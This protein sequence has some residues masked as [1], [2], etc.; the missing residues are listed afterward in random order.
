MLGYKGECFISRDDIDKGNMVFS[1]GMD[2]QNSYSSHL[3]LCEL[4]TFLENLDAEL[5][6]IDFSNVKF[7]AS[8]LFAVLGCIFMEFVERKPGTNR[9]KITGLNYSIKNLI[10]KNGFSIH[11]SEFE[12][13][14]DKF[15]TV[16]AY[17]QFGRDN[18]KEYEMYLTYSIFSRKDLPEMSKEVSDDIRDSLLELFK[19]VSDHTRSKHIYTCGQFFPKSKMLFFTI[20]DAGETIYKNVLE[21]HRRHKLNQPQYCL[22]WAI[23]EGNTTLDTT[24]PRGIGLSLMKDFVKHNKGS[25]YIISGIETYEMVYSKERYRIFEKYS[26]PGT[27]VSIGFNLKDKTSYKVKEDITIQ[28]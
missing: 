27:I 16:I 11:F 4:A 8:N 22:E 2:L 1:I 15:N 21:F 7:I 18:I 26:F 10:Q 19:N 3:K 9:L 20:V 12:K 23:E 17:K 6:T 28:F 14:P 25:I 5:V 24:S 13:Q